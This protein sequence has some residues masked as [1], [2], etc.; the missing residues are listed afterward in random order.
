MTSPRCPYCNAQG[1]KHLAAHK[2]GYFTIVYC[3]RCGAIY[4]VVPNPPQPPPTGQES[5]ASAA[6]PT[7]VPRP[8][9]L[10]TNP[11]ILKTA[12]ETGLDPEQ[13]Q[14]YM[15]AMHSLYPSTR[16]RRVI[17]D[18]SPP[19]CPQCRVAMELW[20]IPEGYKN[21]GR[22]VWRCPNSRRC[23]QWQLAE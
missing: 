12:G 9:P 15:Q 7:E 16:Y 3:G 5:P 6:P 10:D 4:G 22:Q 17:Y 23:R 11:L 13:A 1:I 20:T 19:Q 2:A 14:A 18:P 8:S 21:A